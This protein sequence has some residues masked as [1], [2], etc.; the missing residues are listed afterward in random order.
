MSGKYVELKESVLE[1]PNNFYYN[2]LTKIEKQ[3]YTTLYHTYCF[4]IENVVCNTESIILVSKDYMTIKNLHRASITLSF[5]HPEIFWAEFQGLSCKQEDGKYMIE[6][7]VYE[8]YNPVVFNA[9]A[10]E[11]KRN[12]NEILE[13]LKYI[14]PYP[15]QYKIYAIAEFILRTF[16][17]RDW[18]HIDKAEGIGETQ[19]VGYVLSHK[20]G[21]CAGIANL[22]K[23]LC[24][25]YEIPCVVV[26]SEDHK[27][28]EVQVDGKW[29]LL[30]AT[31]FRLGAKKGF[32][33]F[34]LGKET[35]KQYQNENKYIL[36]PFRYRAN[37]IL[38]KRIDKKAYNKYP[39]IVERDFP[40]WITKKRTFKP[41]I[42][43]E[44]G[45]YFLAQF[46]IPDFLEEN[47]LGEYYVFRPYQWEVM[48]LQTREVISQR[49]TLQHEFS[50]APYDKKYKVLSKS[51]SSVFL[52]KPHQ[53][54]E[55][56]SA[57]L[58]LVID[59][60]LATGNLDMVGYK[61]YLQRVLQNK[62][63]GIRKLYLDLSVPIE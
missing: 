52:K 27:W 15:A 26:H 23:V 24:N 44:N 10:L 1:E 16:T 13:E 56:T 55:N 30:D 37:S 4:D 35:I 31:P 39:D 53:Y 11:Y 38:Y 34:L 51:R 43:Q 17:Y 32:R 60:L 29:Y 45:K 20:E 12:Y 63:S 49:T 8:L 58:N 61:A 33:D 9:D 18:S 7:Y 54:D 46:I 6:V 2:Q 36:E 21:C 62:S 5:E 57:I 48:D 40:Y 47:S 41:V 25:H 42:Y 22:I 19:N 3:I 14:E 28:N 50:D 59:K